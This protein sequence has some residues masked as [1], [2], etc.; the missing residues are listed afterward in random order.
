MRNW[1]APRLVSLA[2]GIGVRLRPLTYT[3]PKA[4]IEFEGI[5]ATEMCFQAFSKL[6]VLEAA[7]VIGHFGNLIQRRIGE[8]FRVPNHPEE[9]LRF[10]YGEDWRVPKK[11]GYEKD[12]MDLIP[13]GTGPGRAGKLKQFIIKHLL[14]WQST[15]LRVLDLESPP[16]TTAAR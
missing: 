6:G 7:I 1:E 16:R 15:R 3:K 9:Y 5:T 4:L 10:K 2:A 8:K 14:P 13:E 11:M 12:V